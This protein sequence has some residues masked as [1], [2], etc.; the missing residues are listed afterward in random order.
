MEQNVRK[1][2]KSL[3]EAKEQL[4]LLGASSVKQSSKRKTTNTT[5]KNT[6]KRNVHKRKRRTR[7]NKSFLQNIDFPRLLRLLFFS[8]VIGFIVYQYYL[9]T[10]NKLDSTYKNFWRNHQDKIV[11]FLLFVGYTLAVFYCGYKIGKKK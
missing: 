11:S 9:L 1:S 2:K 10:E 8:I 5:V 7:K 6:K 3:Q 4:K